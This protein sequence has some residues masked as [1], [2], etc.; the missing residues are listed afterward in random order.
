MT[1]RTMLYLTLGVLAAMVLGTVWFINEF[2]LVPT[3]RWENMKPEARKNRYLALERFAARMGRP[4]TELTD[5]HKLENL[6]QNGVLILDRER[7]RQLPSQ[8]AESLLRWVEQGGYLIVAA[9]SANT[10]DAVLQRLDIS[11]H[12]PKPDAGNTSQA[13]AEKAPPTVQLNIPGAGG[14]ALEHFYGGLVAGRL[15][16]TW[17]AGLEPGKVQVLHYAWGKG[18]ITVFDCFCAFTNNAIGHYDHAEIIWTLISTYQPRGQLWLAARL[19]LPNL[20]EWLADS[21]WM[22]LASAALLVLLWLWHIMPRFGGLRRLPPPERRGLNDHLAAIGRAVWREG[23][24]PHW[25][26]LLRQSLLTGIARRHPQVLQL[27]SPE[28]AAALVRLS[29]M[30][31]DRVLQALER[32]NDH[33]PRAFTETVKAIQQLQQLLQEDRHANFKR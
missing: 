12:E 7:R 27:P 16:P 9:E 14:M 29:G 26:Q 3:T 23:G 5:E 25:R 11:W 30:S 17:Q 21:A 32:Q 31:N 15:R 8:R 6:P 13:K 1:Y 24:L 22:P 33:S 28:R 10:E 20:W 19:K 2:D 18:Q 4:A